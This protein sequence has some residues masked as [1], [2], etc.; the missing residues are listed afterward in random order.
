[1]YGYNAEPPIAYTVLPYCVIIHLYVHSQA[2]VQVSPVLTA[3]NRILL[4]CV[5]EYFIVLMV[6]MKEPISVQVH[7]NTYM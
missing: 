4:V 5:M 3:C 6:V 2:S 7:Y 1:M